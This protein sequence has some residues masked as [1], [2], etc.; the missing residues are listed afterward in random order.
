LEQ[1]QLL[2]AGVAVFRNRCRRLMVASTPR[3]S[4][5]AKDVEASDAI[6]NAKANIQDKEGIP[7]DLRR[8]ILASKLPELERTLSD[9]SV[10]KESTWRWVL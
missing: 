6:D 10:Q 4:T 8:M 5:A 2:S 1:Q 7:P 3:G 9:C